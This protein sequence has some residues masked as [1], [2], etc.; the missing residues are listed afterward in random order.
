MLIKKSVFILIIFAFSTLNVIPVSPLFATTIHYTYDDTGQLVRAEYEED[1]K[2]IQYAYDEV[3]NRDQKAAIP[4]YTLTIN[5]AGTGTGTVTSSPAGIDCGGDCSEVYGEGAQVTLTAV[6]DAGSVFNGWTGGGCS[7]T[8]TCEITMNADTTVTAEFIA[9]PT[10]GFTATPT[11]GDGPL[12][13]DFSDQSTGI[14]DSRLWDFGD[15][16]SSA[17]QDPEHIYTAEGVYTVSLTVENVAGTHTETKT[18]YVTV[19]ACGNQPVRIEGAA[20]VYYATIQEAYDAAADGDVIL[21]Q[22]KEF[23]E[24]VI[25]DDP[26]TVTLE[27]GYDCGYATKIGRTLL[28]GDIHVSNGKV[29]TRDFRL[30]K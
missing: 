4:R 10:A 3:G 17:E 21:I 16:G 24:D 14:I 18:A 19:S 29:T 20:P 5:K 8:G 9:P 25:A 27:G 22:A 1:K 30:V 28:K 13:V 11:T 23:I 6:P 12:K 15:G 26:V 7:G 2:A